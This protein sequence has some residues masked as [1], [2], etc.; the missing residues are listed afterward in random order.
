MYGDSEAL[1]GKWFTRTGNRDKIFLAT[2]FGFEKG[3][4]SNINSSEEYLKQACEESLKLLQTEYIDLYYMH[5]ANPRTPI[6][7]TMRGMLELKRYVMHGLRCDFWTLMYLDS[8]TGQDQIHRPL[9]DQL[10]D[11]SPRLQDRPRRRRADRI[12]PL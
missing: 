10:H 5:R 11:P 4:I 12:R 3:S 8:K 2:K 7:E 1:L 6:E 9:G